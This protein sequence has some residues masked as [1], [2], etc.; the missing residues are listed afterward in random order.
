M[1]NDVLALV[2]ASA[3]LA[4]GSLGASAGPSVPPAVAHVSNPTASIQTVD[5]YCGPRCRYWQHRRWVERHR[6][7]ERRYGYGYY[8][9][10]R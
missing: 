8:G 4:L 1:R 5:Y 7:E 6:R 2:A 9:Y 10:Y 3:F